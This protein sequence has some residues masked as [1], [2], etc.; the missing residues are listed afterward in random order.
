MAL[1]RANFQTLSGIY[2]LHKIH[3]LAV[4][5]SPLLQLPVF[6]YVSVDLR[7]IVNG[8]DPALAQELVES[9]VGWIPDLTEPD[10]W[11]GLPVLAGLIMYANVEVALG[12]R[13]LSGPA[14]ARSDTAGIVKDAFQSLAVFMPCFTSQLP[15]GVQIYLVT[16]FAFTYVQSAALRAE[17]FRKFVGLPSM[18]SPPPEAKYAQEFIELKKLEQKAN[19]LRGDGPVLGTGVLAANL[20]ASFAGSYRRSTIRGSA[21]G[22]SVGGMHP[23]IPSSSDTTA[24]AAST[25][26]GLSVRPQL[27]LPPHPGPFIHGVSAPSWQLAEQQAPQLRE[28]APLHPGAPRSTAPFGD[29]HR[30]FMPVHSDD[31]MDKANRGERPVAPQFVPRPAPVDGPSRLST[32]RLRSRKGPSSSPWEAVKRKPNS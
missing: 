12:R 30:E 27:A 23:A 32:K 11:F 7:K 19:E 28:E 5:W 25:T 15:G 1:I 26:S 3:P 16:S 22:R 31:V 24:A 6:W 29:G 2:Q 20:R 4:F 10:P 9:G 18:L 14:A 21:I 13:S 8:L 17:P